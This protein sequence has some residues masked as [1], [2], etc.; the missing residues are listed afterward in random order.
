MKVNKENKTKVKD[1]KH[2]TASKWVKFKETEKKQARDKLCEQD[3][4]IKQSES[5][6]KEKKSNVTQLFDD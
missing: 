6:Q 4:K 1:Q 5:E 3:W 2:E